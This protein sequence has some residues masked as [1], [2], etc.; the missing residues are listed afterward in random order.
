MPPQGAFDELSHIRHEVLNALSLVSPS[1]DG[2]MSPSGSGD[3]SVWE[4]SLATLEGLQQRYDYSDSG[5]EV[6]AALVVGL[7]DVLL[8]K[9]GQGLV[10]VE[11]MLVQMLVLGDGVFHGLAGW[12]SYGRQDGTGPTPSPTAALISLWVDDLIPRVSSGEFVAWVQE[13]LNL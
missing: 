7:A 1:P 13:G 4:A 11:P 10:T 8:A 12:L 5:W 9:G 2:I 6:K 3:A